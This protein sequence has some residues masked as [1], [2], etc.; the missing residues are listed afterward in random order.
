MRD[1]LKET[2]TTYVTYIVEDSIKRSAAIK[3]DFTLLGK[4]S[5]VDM[6]AKQARYHES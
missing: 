1:G 4:I 6:V 3:K 5:G 2:L